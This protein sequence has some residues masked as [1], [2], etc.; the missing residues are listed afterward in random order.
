MLS[1]LASHPPCTVEMEAC[2][3]AHYL[4]REIA[5]LDHEAR[6]DPP[7]YVKPF[8]KRQKKDA[9]DAEATTEGAERPDDALRG[10]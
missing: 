1:F 2:A 10:G 7:V 4:G 6:L 9:A 5:A 8:V 3:S